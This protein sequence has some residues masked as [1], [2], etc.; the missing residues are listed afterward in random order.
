MLRTS[1]GL[2]VEQFDALLAAQ[3]GVCAICGRPQTHKLWEEL[4]VDHDHTTGKVRALLCHHCNVMVGYAERDPKVL[5]MTYEY[6][7]EHKCE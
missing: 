2:T 7:R 5:L 6:L 3:N 4:C 1:Y